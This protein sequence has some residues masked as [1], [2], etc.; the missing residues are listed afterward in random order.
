MR[1]Q[2]GV[3]LTQRT[4][5]SPACIGALASLSLCS[6][7]PLGTE[8]GWQGTPCRR[9]HAGVQAG[10]GGK[11]TE[12]EGSGKEKE[13][14]GAGQ[15]LL[16][17]IKLLYLGLAH[18]ELLDLEALGPILPSSPTSTSAHMVTFPVCT[19]TRRLRRQAWL[20]TTKRREPPPAKLPRCHV[21]TLPRR[22]GGS[23]AATLP[24]R[25]TACHAGT[26]ARRCR[27]RL[28]GAGR[29]HRLG[30]RRDASGERRGA[31]CV[32][33]TPRESESRRQ[34]VTTCTVHRILLGSMTYGVASRCP[35]CMSDLCLKA[36]SS[37][38]ALSRSRIFPAFTV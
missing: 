12:T 4:P 18:E 31:A 20:P 24:W 25:H 23:H 35:L 32:N 6:G 33:A 19:R 34:R 7:W 36:T 21:A 1:L 27:Q 28:S 2:I 29:K 9:T 5:P 3:R 22:H 16:I 13:R 17:P 37:V 38:S 8:K 30:E 15:D 11:G 26:L 10:A 14:L